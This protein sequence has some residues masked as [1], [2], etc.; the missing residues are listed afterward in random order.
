MP[1]S[2]DQIVTRRTAALLILLGGAA[3]CA[4]LAVAV[5][6]DPADRTVT[7]TS[8]YS[9]SAVGHAGLAGLLREV[10]YDVQ[11]NRSRLGRSIAPEDVLLILE[12]NLRIHSVAELQ[13]LMDGKR[14]VLV[15]L[16]KWAHA[17]DLPGPRGWI[18]EAS[19]LS[20][21]TAGKVARG[22]VVPASINRSDIDQPWTDRLGNGAPTIEGDLQLVNS[23]Q[24]DALLASSD[25]ALVGE[26]TDRDAQIIVLADPDIIANHG[27]HR[28]DNA[29]F[30]LG[31]IDRLKPSPDAT[32]HFDETLHG[33]A[34]VPSLPRLLMAPPFL[35]AT[36]LV[37]GAVAVTVWRAAV[38][39]G[40]PHG[41]GQPE[42]V[43]GS[44]HETLLRNAGRLLAAGDDAAYIADRYARVSLE[45]AARRLHLGAQSRRGEADND[46]K[47][48]GVLE[49][50][51]ARRGVRTRLPGDEARP[52]A[53]ARRHYD[54]IEE[55]FR[56]SGS[57]RD[58]R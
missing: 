10:G 40:K 25:G 17:N 18:E 51:A 20:K 53:K 44:G 29:R 7:G 41:A 2:S 30:A 47:A 35:A 56:G 22:V 36:L 57:S 1:D 52:L 9:R 12:P 26:M 23:D 27:L 15:A 50:I 58:P 13:R 39:F 34:I 37:L 55:M 5:V 24:L 48:R 16:P 54:W 14:R 45:E 43:F 21:S 6:I 32:V 19:L 8:S 38:G 3:T 42:P 28:G 33:F 46:V 11:V 4:L 49:D 31:L